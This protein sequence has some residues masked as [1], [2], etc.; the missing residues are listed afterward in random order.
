[1][2]KAHAA[3]LGLDRYF[4]GAGRHAGLPHLEKNEKT[5]GFLPFWTSASGRPDGLACANCAGNTEK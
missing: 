5:K 4:A 2:Q 1:M 3:P